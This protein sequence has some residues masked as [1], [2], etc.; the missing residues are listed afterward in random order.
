MTSYD[1]IDPDL[2]P[3]VDNFPGISWN[4]LTLPDARAFMD[5]MVDSVPLPDLPVEI[6]TRTIA[7]AGEDGEIMLVLYRPTEAQGPLPALID[8]HGGGY[9]AGTARF[10]APRNAALAHDLG[11]L[12]VSVDYR[13]APE[14]PYPAGLNDCYAGLCWLHRQ[15]VDIGVD[16][17]RIAIAGDSAGGG[18]AA[19]LALM[20]RDRGEV[21]LVAQILTY[22]M[23]DDRTSSTVAHHPLAGEFIWDP[24]ANRFA[25]DAYLG[26]PPGGMVDGY[27]VP[28]RFAD[29]AGLPP[30]MI[31]VGQLDLFIAEDIEY[32]R[33]LI[34]AGVPTELHVYPGAFHGF[35][36]MPEAASSIAHAQAVR[37]A[38]RRAFARN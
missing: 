12:I 22:P 13:L 10:G 17:A 5:Q 30:A 33:R 34:E 18:L 25:W 14:A 9:V 31:A 35:D 26:K 20:A 28:G 36:L 19:A 6:T 2:R 11:C 24:S 15:A 32:A 23:L 3:M 37:G 21:P 38:L 7:R 16:P 27:S 1:L 29:L 8:I 4:A